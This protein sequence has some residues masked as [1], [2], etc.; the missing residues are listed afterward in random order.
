M[1]VFKASVIDACECVTHLCEAIGNIDGSVVWGDGSFPQRQ[2]MWAVLDATIN[3]FYEKGV[4][5]EDLNDALEQ[6]GWE[7]NHLTIVNGRVKI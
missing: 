1:G 7:D 5:L 2:A 4:T 6:A 3:H